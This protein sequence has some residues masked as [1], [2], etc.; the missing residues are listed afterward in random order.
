MLVDFVW[1][2]ATLAFWFSAPLMLGVAVM[3]IYNSMQ[4]M[5]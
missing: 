5:G 2:M 1:M 4:R 3:I